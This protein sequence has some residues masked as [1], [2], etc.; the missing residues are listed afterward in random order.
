MKFT[1]LVLCQASLLGGVVAAQD[2]PARPASVDAREL[3][4]GKLP[5]GYR[6][7][8]L[9]TVAREEGKLDDIRAI[10]GNDIAIDALRKG[11]RPFPDGTV[12]ARLAWSLVP[13]QE[14][15][16]AFGNVQSFVAGNPK[17]GVQFMV[18]DS[19]L[20]SET[21]GW[22]YFQFDDGSPLTNKAKL[23]SCFDCHQTIHHR[24]YVFS[25][26]SQ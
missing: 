7:W 4:E 19:S 8:K 18:K 26:Y 12:I 23:Q 1:L 10:L 25:R 16:R 2:A 20:Y 22:R 15:N 5:T 14:N 24:D 11:T 6:D 21:G 17:N 3:V 9:V 13:S